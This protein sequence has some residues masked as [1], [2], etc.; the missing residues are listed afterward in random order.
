MI[1]FL[2]LAIACSAVTTGA[3]AAK[4]AAQPGGPFRFECDIALLVRPQ[5]QFTAPAPVTITFI[6]ERGALRD[7]HVVDKGGILYPGGTFRFVE[8][9]DAISMETVDMPAE[10]PG[11]WTGTLEKKM[12]RLKLANGGVADAVTISLGRTPSKSTGRYGLVWNATN[13][14]AGLPQPLSGTGGGNCALASAQG[15]SK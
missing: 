10:R 2:A 3:A 15:N 7:I 11:R 1:R 5:G 6:V 13:Q 9:R 14:P 8:K 4:K 12:Y